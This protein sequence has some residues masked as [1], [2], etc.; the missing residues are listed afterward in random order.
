MSGR[1]NLYVISLGIQPHVTHLGFAS[2]GPFMY[3]V[4]TSKA[5][6]ILGKIYQN[7]MLTRTLRPRNAGIQAAIEVVMLV[8]ASGLNEVREGLTKLF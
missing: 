7:R 1:P 8:A 4:S 3:L 6:A 5:F 2:K